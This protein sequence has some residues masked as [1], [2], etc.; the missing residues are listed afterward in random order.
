ME[1]L[2]ILE[3]KIE[4]MLAGNEEQMK[5]VASPSDKGKIELLN[6]EIELKDDVWEKVVEVMTM[7]EAETRIEEKNVETI[8]IDDLTRDMHL[9]RQRNPKCLFSPP[10]SMNLI[11]HWGLRNVL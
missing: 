8:D 7:I 1:H 6:K 10:E 5:H 3:C 2:Q 9:K 4:K 11:L